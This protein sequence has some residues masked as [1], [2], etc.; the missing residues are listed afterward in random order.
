MKSEIVLDKSAFRE[1]MKLLDVKKPKCKYC[2]VQVKKNNFG[3]IA[4]DI[5]S[6]KNICCL[7]QAIHEQ[8]H[9]R[10]I[11]NWQKKEKAGER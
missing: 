1:V 8:E 7:I 6:C 11:K 4:K 9:E 5:I 2:G 3:L 10:D